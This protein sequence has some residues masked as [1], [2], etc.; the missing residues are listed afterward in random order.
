MKMKLVCITVFV[1]FISLQNSSAQNKVS[2]LK[3]ILS[4]EEPELIKLLGQYRFADFL[5]DPTN[6]KLDNNENSDTDTLELY[7]EVLRKVTALNPESYDEI[8]EIDYFLPQLLS[9]I[10]N[11]YGEHEY[12]KL[13][14][15]YKSLS[16]TFF[17]KGESF[18]IPFCSYLVY[19]EIDFSIRNNI[20]P[21]ADFIFLGNSNNKTNKS[22]YFQYC[23]ELYNSIEKHYEKRILR[24]TSCGYYSY[25]SNSALFYE[26]VEEILFKSTSE[27]LKK[28]NKFRW[29]GWCGTG[30]E[31]F[32]SQQYLVELLILLRERDFYSVLGRKDFYSVPNLG[33]KT[34][35]KFLELCDIDWI[36]YYTGAILSGKLREVPSVFTKTGSDKAA[37]NLLAIKDSIKYKG[38]YIV[39]CAEF[40]NS[41]FEKESGY[42]DYFDSNQFLNKYEYSLPDSTIPINDELKKKLKR[43]IISISSIEEDFELCQLAINALQKIKFDEDVKKVLLLY[44]KS[45]YSIIRN[46]AANI[47]KK[48]GIL[49]ELPNDDGKIK[50][51]FLVDG[52]PLKK[53][54]IRWE[55]YTDLKQERPILNGSDNTDEDGILYI[56]SD[57]FL[58]RIDNVKK[59]VFYPDGGGKEVI[60]LCES[61]LPKNLKDTTII[62]VT[63]V[64][65]SI[66]FHL[67]RNADFYKGKKMG[68]NAFPPKLIML[69]FT[70]DIRDVFEFP[71]KFQKNIKSSFSAYVPGAITWF[72]PGRDSIKND[73]IMDAYLKNG[74]NVTFELVAPGGDKADKW[75]LFDLK[76]VGNSEWDNFWSYDYELG[77][78]ESLSVGE[79]RLIISSSKEKKSNYQKKGNECSE[80]IVMDFP[81][82]EGKIITFTIAE[83]SP[84]QI[85]LGI[86]ELEPAK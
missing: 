71:M 33:S 15:F 80:E 4:K 5:Y 62:Y 42:F 11:R 86:I 39:K 46:N 38:W 64:K 67:N 3:Q 53:D 61:Q 57:T 74:T 7:W 66:R 32:Y 34:K 25:Q 49:V 47:L 76:R 35:T 16:D 50:Y 12:E 56:L 14:E 52:K 65:V 58:D 1:F 22:L 59:I 9:D 18:L 31:Y 17:S 70:S 45:K 8:L 63:T 43:E 21:D 55:L 68:I 81:D 60:F 29:G 19:K 85:D 69:D 13:T 77:G 28:L 26:T 36:D 37:L 44:T 10:L 75:P 20:K 82:Y 6:K 24:D 23:K 78:Y 40:I 27:D 79:Y 73:L 72:S 51:K 30:S 83:D 48:Q 41:S 84:P 54:R 2:V